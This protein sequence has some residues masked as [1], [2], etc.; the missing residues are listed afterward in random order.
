MLP[1]RGPGSLRGGRPPAQAG[2]PHSG[3]QSQRLTGYQG[4]LHRLKPS[5]DWRGD[6][7]GSQYCPPRRPRTQASWKQNGLYCHQATIQAQGG[8]I[9]TRTHYTEKILVKLIQVTMC[10]LWQR[11]GLAMV[12][13]L[14]SRGASSLYRTLPCLSPTAWWSCT[15][16]GGRP[17][18]TTS[19]RCSSPAWRPVAH[20]APGTGAAHARVPL[21]RGCCR[22]SLQPLAGDTHTIFP[23]VPSLFDQI[24]SNM[25]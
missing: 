1:G 9:I 10:R 15:G 17:A 6:N 3:R 13:P 18:A 16:C 21:H 19:T 23:T 24:R 2:L 4:F 8:M 12:S 20:A 25:T 14:P 11:N 7:R 5:L 22:R